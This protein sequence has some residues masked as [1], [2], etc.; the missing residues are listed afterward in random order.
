MA[1]ANAFGKVYQYGS[2]TVAVAS[3]SYLAI[4]VVGDSTANVYKQTTYANQP[5]VWTFVDSVSNQEKVLDVGGYTVRIDAGADIVSYAVCANSRNAVSVMPSW[6]IAPGQHRFMDDFDKYAAG[7]WTITKTGAGGSVA[8]GNVDGGVL[9]LT[10]DTADND[11]VF[12]NKVGE[13]FLFE[14][15]KKLYFEARLKASD[16]TQSDFVI[17]LQITDT[18]PLAVTDGTYFIKADDAA[19]VD[20][21]VV[22]N[23]T[24]TTASAIATFANDTF[25][26]LG[27]YYDGVGAIYYYVNR[28]LAGSSVTTNLCD[29]EE[30]TVSIGVQAGAAAAKSITV[31]FVEIIKER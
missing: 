13:S 29:D 23:S 5:P 1:T 26:T 8:L 30:L 11:N 28:V 7:D 17:G 15:G 4:S 6:P 3:G 16:A 12:M 21:V 10:T 14:T 27:F 22:K 20:F 24:A 31:D 19:T 18:T 9:V 25:K 2:D